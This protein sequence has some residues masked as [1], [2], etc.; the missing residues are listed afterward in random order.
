[1]RERPQSSWIDPPVRRR[2]WYY[3]AT[4]HIVTYTKT[5]QVTLNKGCD[6]QV[7]VKP[8]A[9]RPPHLYLSKIHKEGTPLRYIVSSTIG[10]PTYEIAKFLAS[11]L[12][13]HVKKCEHRVKFF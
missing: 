13:K 1:M 5:L 9:S 7:L 6:V 12:S 3:Q 2:Y 11:L 4:H 10:A 8:H